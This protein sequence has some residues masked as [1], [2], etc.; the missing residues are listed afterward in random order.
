MSAMGRVATRRLVESMRLV[1]AVLV[2]YGGATLLQAPIESTCAPSAANPPEP[3]G[4]WAG[5]SGLVGAIVGFFGR[6]S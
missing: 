2:A 1:F 6:S 5:V 4:L 3:S